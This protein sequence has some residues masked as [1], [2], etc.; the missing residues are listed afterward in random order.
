M[1]PLILI[2]ETAT[3]VCSVALFKGEKL[4]ASKES[5]LQNMHSKNILRFL[6]NIFNS[7]E[8]NLHNLNAVAFSNGPGS[9]TGLR[10]GLTTAKALAYTL[11]IPLLTYDTLQSSAHALCKLNNYENNS[12][13]VAA[14]DARRDEIYVHICDDKLNTILSTTNLIVTPN[15]FNQY[16]DNKNVVLGG[17]ANE[18]IL[19]I[20]NKCNI[21]NDEHNIFSSIIAIDLVLERYSDKKFTDVAY[22][23]PNYVKNFF[24]PLKT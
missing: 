7:V 23:E 18:K 12:I 24:T 17:N 16:I 2:L 6:Q 11:E 8:V 15:C 10:I 1:Q 20:V 13:F 14:I 3:N 22:S 9:Y 4:L 21:K 19:E 5:T